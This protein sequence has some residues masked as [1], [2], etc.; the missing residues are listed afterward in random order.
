MKIIDH[1]VLNEGLLMLF[2]IYRALLCCSLVECLCA[3]FAATASRTTNP[4]GALS[5]TEPY[6]DRVVIVG[7]DSRVITF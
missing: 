3:S 2:L 1:D 4:L 7:V 6:T 5:V